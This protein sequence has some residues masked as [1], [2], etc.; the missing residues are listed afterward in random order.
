MGTL[1]EVHLAYKRYLQEPLLRAGLT[2]KQMTLLGALSRRQF[3]C[4]SEIAD[5]FFSDRPTVSGMLRG[6][7]RKGWLARERDPDNA[8]RVRVVL[9]PAGRAKLEEVRALPEVRRR[10]RFD[11][12]ACLDED[13]K[14][15]LAAL[16]ARVK[17]HLDDVAQG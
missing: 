17:T 11:P 7:E 10:R 6:M 1:A 14:E 15:T 9:L 12:L 8:R 13:E 2:I 4:P 5:I 16:L 3:L